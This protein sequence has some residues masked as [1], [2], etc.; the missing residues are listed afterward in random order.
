LAS[1]PASLA[2]DD[3]INSLYREIAADQ[4]VRSTIS[5]IQFTDLHVDLEYLVGSNNEC[6][7]VLCCR[8]EDGMATDP[9]KAAGPYGF[10]GVCDVP[11]SVLDK[12]TVKVNELAPD[13]L[14]WTGDV[15]P[16]D[17]WNYSQEYVENY[18][19]FL[20]NYM[21]ENLNEWTTFPLEG[22]HDFGLVIN[23]QDFD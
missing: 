19:S 15:A 9:A 23:S 14:F 22:N 17:Q 6:D 11:V 12:M 13:T 20:F 5:I 3:F 7:N 4:T 18:Q 21:Q 2:D 1:K 10:P 16:H 8:L